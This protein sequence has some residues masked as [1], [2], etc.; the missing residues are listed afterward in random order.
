LPNSEKT[1]HITLRIALESSIGKDFLDAG[2][3]VIYGIAAIINVINE[4]PQ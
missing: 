1:T 4:V 3:T 2:M